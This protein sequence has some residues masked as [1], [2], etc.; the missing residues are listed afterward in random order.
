MSPTNSSRQKLHGRPGHSDIADTDENVT[1]RFTYQAS[2]NS[3]QDELRMQTK[4][5]CP[6]TLS[7]STSIHEIHSYL[8]SRNKVFGPIVIQCTVSKFP[9]R[10][11]DLLTIKTDL[12]SNPYLIPLE[13]QAKSILPQASLSFTGS[14]IQYGSSRGPN[15]LS[16]LSRISES[17]FFFLVWIFQFLSIPLVEIFSFTFTSI[18]SQSSINH[19]LI[20]NFKTNQSNHNSSFNFQLHL[21]S[22][23]GC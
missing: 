15:R 8:L 9:R 10:N 14:A 19:L 22:Q 5:S 2:Q 6:Y 4:A 16:R 7:R 20:L 17:D 13:I 3:R 12:L 23:H 18:C 1:P 21:S 11:R